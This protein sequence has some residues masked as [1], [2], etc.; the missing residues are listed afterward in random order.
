MNVKTK[1]FPAPSFFVSREIYDPTPYEVSDGCET[2]DNEKP[3]EVFDG[4]LC[5]VCQKH[6][7]SDEY[8][9]SISHPQD[10]FDK[11]QR[12]VHSECIAECVEKFE[13]LGFTLVE[14]TGEWWER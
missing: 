2:D 7:M 4:A 9:T 3:F 6:M 14:D 8:I 1:N 5:P 11:L 10:T 13:A 12:Y